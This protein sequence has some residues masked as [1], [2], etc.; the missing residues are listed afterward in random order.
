MIDIMFP[1]QTNGPVE[2]ALFDLTVDNNVDPMTVVTSC[3]LDATNWKYLG[4]QQSGI[5]IY[6]VK[7][8]S[9]G[10]VRNL[11]EAK[12][13]AGRLNPK[14]R[15]LEGQAREPFKEKYPRHNGRP[16]VFGGSQWQDP[17]DSR[18][19]AYLG[20][21]SVGEWHSRFGWSDG[22]FHD[23]RLWPVVEQG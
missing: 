5:R 17:D 18:N 1:S 3:G 22:D 4:P 10:S 9:L 23:D 11:D 7:L 21:L 6:R 15:L 8:V 13:A 2:D 20:T 19:V 14:F 12:K 16:I